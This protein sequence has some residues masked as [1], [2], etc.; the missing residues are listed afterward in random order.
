MLATLLLVIGAGAVA[1]VVAQIAP[2]RDHERRTVNPIAL[3]VIS[4]GVL[5]MYVTG[6]LVAA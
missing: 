1:Q 3:G 5:V 6:I 2:V 4:I